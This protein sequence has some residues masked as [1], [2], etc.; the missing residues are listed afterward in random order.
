[1]Q[2]TLTPGLCSSLCVSQSNEGMWEKPV[3]MLFWEPQSHMREVSMQPKVGNS[4]GKRGH[5]E[6]TQSWLHY[7]LK[8]QLL[9]LHRESYDST[10]N[11]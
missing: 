9:L 1:M 6:V 5:T 4:S 7:L 11:L 10:R 8:E 2:K 3:K